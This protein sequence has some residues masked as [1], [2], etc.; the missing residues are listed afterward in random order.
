[1]TVRSVWG[2][3]PGCLLLVGCAVGPNYH[4]PEI[5]VPDAFVA[6]AST[7][8]ATDLSQ[9]WLSFNDPELNSLIERA[10]RANPDIEIALTRLQEVRTQEAAHISAAL[11]AISASAAGGRGTGSDLSVAGAPPALRAADNKDGLAQIRQVAGFSASWELDLF[12]GYRRA[13]E[14]GHY[15]IGAATAARDDVLV[16]VIADVARSYV[17]IRGLTQ[18]R[19]ILQDDIAAA[20]QSWDFAKTRFERG[21]TNE[22]D[23]QLAERELATLRAQL[24]LLTSAISARQNDLAT[25]L[26]TYTD[27]IAGEFT[28]AGELPQPPAQLQPGLPVDLLRRR[29]DI[30]AAERQ[31]AGATA[32]I[33]V[34][35][36]N[37]FPHLV[38]SGGLGTQSGSVGFEGSHIWAFGPSLYWPLLDFGALDAQVDVADLRAHE[39]LVAYKKTIIAA[40]RDTDTAF[41][42]Y[43]AQEER[44]GSLRQARTASERALTLAQQRY[45]RGLTDFLN[46]VDAEQQQF[47]LQDEYTAAQQSAA[48]AYINV[49][50]ALGGGWERY[51]QLPAI[52]HPQPA[53]VAGIRHLIQP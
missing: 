8:S 23:L 14:A 47:S 16:S 7:A 12:G 49:C 31:L 24:P 46:V 32:R 52:A 44:L 3:V 43:S 22:L 15:D 18:R 40:V 28:R 38:L 34:A 20:V 39:S 42:S 17:D 51:Q 45:D 11:P 48:D 53:V 29:P 10:I 37:L 2:I 6:S 26:G 35:T 30:R 9:W 33:G 4:V 5:P 41:A 27:D 36:A 25:L 19:T 50:Q 13:I 1:M 21:L